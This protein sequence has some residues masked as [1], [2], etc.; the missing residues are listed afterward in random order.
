MSYRHGPVNDGER[1]PEGRVVRGPSMKNKVKKNPAIVKGRSI[2]T[3]RPNV[4]CIERVDLDLTRG[5]SMNRV[6]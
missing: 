2:S 4:N 1:G 5:P 3:S 6:L